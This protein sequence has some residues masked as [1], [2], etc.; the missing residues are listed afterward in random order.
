M[1]K[2]K[3]LRV[4]VAIIATI[5]ALVTLASFGANL[6]ISPFSPVPFSTPISA[7]TNG[8]TTVVADDKARRL[9]ILDDQYRLTDIVSFDSLNSPI[10]AVTD[11]CAA[12]DAIYVVGKRY[13]KG[14]DLIQQERVVRYDFRG[15]NPTIVYET[16]ES[17]SPTRTIVGICDSGQDVIITLHET[18]VRTEKSEVVFTRIGK[19]IDS[20]EV[21]KS[22]DTDIAMV[23]DSG[24]SFNNKQFAIISPR[25]IINDNMSGDDV[26]DFGD[27]TLL[28]ID[29]TED[30]RIIVSDDV[31]GNLFLVDDTSQ[32][33][34]FANG[35]RFDQLHANGDWVCAC[36]GESNTVCLYDL[37]GNKRTEF[38][39]AALATPLKLYVAVAQTCRA[40]LVLLL[41]WG[42][43]HCA[44][45][46]IKG[47]V[48][49]VGALFAATSVVVAIA[50]AIGYTSYGSYQESRSIR[51]NEVNAFADYLD[52][53]AP[54]FSDDMAVCGKRD[55]FKRDGEQLQK[56]FDALY[57]ID[58]TVG[59]LCDSANY[60]GI[61]S[62]FAVYARDDKGVFYLYDSTI[63]H[64]MG[65]GT[66]SPSMLPAIEEAFTPGT[67]TSQI[68]IGQTARDDSQYRL[69]SI[70]SPDGS[71]IA[72]VIE[73]GSRAKSFET[74][75]RDSIMERVITLLAILLVVYISYVEIRECGKCLLSYR[76]LQRNN[77][78][79][80]LAV[81]TRPFSFL[82]TTL[83]SI[84]AVMSTLIAKELLQ[85]TPE[86]GN[87]M[88]VA[89][90]ALMLGLGMAFG[91]AAYGFLGPRVE[92]R[93]LMSRSAALMAVG[94]LCAMMAVGMGTYWMYCVAK[95]AMAIP[96]GLLYT[97]GYS[98]PRRAETP[99]VQALAAGGIKRTDTSAAAFGT[100]LGAFAASTLG[101]EWVYVVMAVASVVVMAF[102]LVLFPANGKPL[103]HE[104]NRNVDTRTLL[105][106]FLLSRETL[107]DTLLIMLPATIAAGYS[108]FVF[109]L[110]S[111]E[112]GLTTATI[113]NLCVLG[114]LVV[115]V[116]ISSI[117]RFEGRYGK[118][119]VSIVAVA[120]LG[121]TFLL[122]S[123]NNTVG[124]AVAAIAL[125]GV[126]KKASDGWKAMWLKSAGKYGLPAGKATGAMFATNGIELVIRPVVLGAIV[127]HGS[128][129]SLV[130]G[131][132]CA[133]CAGLFWLVTRHTVLKET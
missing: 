24:Y 93:R 67:D 14:S 53:I 11:V 78:R 54:S 128:V 119:L 5:S 59:S 22:Y 65:T 17:V 38:S 115:F 10:D 42:I 31:T 126:F 86:A 7:D 130:L 40:I 73:I 33:K 61:G 48:H 133:A 101:N 8:S 83:S 51:A 108:S 57:H 122:F 30:G 132:L 36:N 37:D 66:I 118:W 82:V 106:R 127:S 47:G 105:R 55:A 9:L 50:I 2:R 64:V 34:L 90:P 98:L 4:I 12:R 116:C 21:I 27:K 91:H 76:E 94:A 112:I 72:G 20:S 99:D 123:L 41:V 107:A 104:R 109:P 79:D 15:Q 114:Q 113:N 35:R 29:I 77:A 62:Y 39:E 25:G 19:D 100:V 52:T 81:L 18:D 16:K 58:N 97:L 110:Y 102:A 69:V 80:S 117:E 63:E 45:I 111:S 103:E 49:G 87:T 43:I 131:I 23:Y 121:A 13:Y 71:S 68:R 129:A 75:I 84:D 70:P 60:N 120:L 56:S 89:L 32:P 85:S 74:S 96:F 88:M 1:D 6:P 28:A 92:L 44:R 26:P 124:W 3:V 125:I 46:V 95:L